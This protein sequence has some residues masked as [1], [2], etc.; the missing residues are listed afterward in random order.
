VN[1][2][3]QDHHSH[4]ADGYKQ[5]NRIERCFRRLKTSYA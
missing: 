2:T 3:W 4:D 5:R 1:R